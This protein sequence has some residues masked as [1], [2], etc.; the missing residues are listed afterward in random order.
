MDHICQCGKKMYIFQN[1]GK[2][3]W[4][5]LTC[6]AKEDITPRDVKLCP[7]CGQILYE[8]VDDRLFT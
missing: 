4:E 7:V 2:F 1:N 5:C 8:D 3:W 6:N